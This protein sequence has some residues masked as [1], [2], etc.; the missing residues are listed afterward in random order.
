MVVDACI[1][2]LSDLLVIGAANAAFAE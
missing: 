2:E 1:E